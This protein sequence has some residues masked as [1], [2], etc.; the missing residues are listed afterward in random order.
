MSDVR[1]VPPSDE[2]LKPPYISIWL[3]P[4]TEESKELESIIREFANEFDTFEFIPHLTVVSGFYAQPETVAQVIGPLVQDTTVLNLH[5]LSLGTSNKI[6]QTLF[7]EMEPT[8]EFTNYC[9]KY[10]TVLNEYGSKTTKPHLSLIYKKGG[11]E[12]IDASK[13]ERFNELQKKVQNWLLSKSLITF[14]RV[15][16]VASERSLTEDSDVLNYR[17]IEEYKF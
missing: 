6:T 7:I 5:P 13:I 11:I 2:L 9:D 3:L 1:D 17:V 4:S 10:Q 12:G 8:T 14:D 15:A 16:L